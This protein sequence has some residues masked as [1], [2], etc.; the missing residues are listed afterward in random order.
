MAAASDADRDGWLDT[1][2]PTERDDYE[3][4]APNWWNRQP[5]PAADDRN[6][7]PF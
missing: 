1:L 5:K 4:G 3:R 6:E 7:L 2:T